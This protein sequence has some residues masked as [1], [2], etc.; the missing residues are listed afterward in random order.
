[1]SQLIRT[2]RLALSGAEAEGL[3]DPEI[4]DVIMQIVAEGDREV[5]TKGAADYI[6]YSVPTLKLWRYQKKGPKYR[7]SE[8]GRIRYKIKYLNEHM[9]DG[10]V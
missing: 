5:D 4:R 9:N 10:V 7:R 8:N 2:I 1:M 3:P 6:D